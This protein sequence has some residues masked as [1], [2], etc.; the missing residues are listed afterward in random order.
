[1]DTGI[2]NI[3]ASTSHDKLPALKTEIIN[4]I[5]KICESITSDEVE[6][7][8]T[9]IRTSIYLSQEKSSYKSEEIGKNFA[10]FHKYISTEKT[11]EYLSAIQIS[12][13]IEVARTIFATKPTLAVIGSN[14]NIL[15]YNSICY[16]LTLERS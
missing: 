12:D 14:P 13:I 16:D 6:R 10:I 1:M 7:A 9:Q 2:F 11:M 8:K 3:Y 4:E 5:K 15:D